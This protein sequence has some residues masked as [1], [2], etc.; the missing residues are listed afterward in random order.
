M[1]PPPLSQPL[2]L[3][4]TDYAVDQLSCLQ[5]ARQTSSFKDSNVI[6]RCAPF[7]GEVADAASKLIDEVVCQV[8]IVDVNVDVDVDID[9]DERALSGK[10]AWGSNF[11]L[12]RS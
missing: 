3:Q 6:R 11:Q 1:H 10:Q 5:A 4:S 12:R 9:I 2:G 8:L 7:S